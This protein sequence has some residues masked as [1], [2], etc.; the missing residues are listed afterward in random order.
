[1]RIFFNTGNNLKIKTK[2]KAYRYWF[3]LGAHYAYLDKWFSQVLLWLVLFAWVPVVAFPNV[4][5]FQNYLGIFAFGLPSVGIFIM[6][7][8]LL[9]IPYYVKK[10]NEKL[11]E[12][13]KSFEKEKV[14][15]EE[16]G[17]VGYPITY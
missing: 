5:F 14:V 4:A 3:F 6:I 1:M 9:F 12:R 17:H 2:K 16:K 13:K 15:K 8:D 11:S 7:S 10:F